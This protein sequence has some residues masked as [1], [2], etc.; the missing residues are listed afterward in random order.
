MKKLFMKKLFMKKLF[1]K[2]STLL[3]TSIAL[4]TPVSAEDTVTDV[5]AKYSNNSKVEASDEL[6]QSLNLGFSNTTGNTKTLNVNGKYAL[7]F[8]SNGFQNNSLKTA[9]DASGFFTE[10][11]NIKNNEEYLANLGL[12]QML[13]RGWL[14]Y[15]GVNWLSNPDFRNY[16]NKIAIGLGVGKELYNDGQHL[17]TAKLG[18][19]YN[20][21]DFSND[22]DTEEFGALNEYLEYANQLNTISK[23]YIKVGSMQNFDNF[24][25]DYEVLGIVGV[26]FAVAEN[27]NLSL[28]GEALNDNLPALGFKKTDTKTIVRLGYNF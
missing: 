11:N 17:F 25:N 7:S 9:F 18:V 24:S 26:N 14:G 15:T 5:E 4:L 27:I 6:K 3:F 20:I 10:N 28:E 8:I 2:V 19:S 12:E 16:D 1:T 22:Q 13:G 23:L 21:E